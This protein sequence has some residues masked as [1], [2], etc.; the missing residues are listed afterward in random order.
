MLHEMRRLYV[1][2]SRSLPV[3][4]ISP[5]KGTGL[6]LYTIITRSLEITIDS[7]VVVVTQKR[8]TVRLFSSKASVASDPSLFCLIYALNP[9]SRTSLSKFVALRQRKCV[10]Q[11]NMRERMHFTGL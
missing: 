3:R 7:V 4:D 8:A 2:S 6:T 11:R 10:V 9:G 1:S 5:K